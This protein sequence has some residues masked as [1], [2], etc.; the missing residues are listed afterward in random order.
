MNFLYS[1][2]THSLLILNSIQLT[3]SNIFHKRWFT[4]VSKFLKK[5]EHNSLILNI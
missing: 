3:F 4:Y 2:N 1:I 5:I